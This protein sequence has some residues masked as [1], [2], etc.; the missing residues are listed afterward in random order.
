MRLWIKAVLLTLWHGIKILAVGTVAAIVVRIPFMVLSDE[1]RLLLAA[2]I[3]AAFALALA[4][5]LIWLFADAVRDNYGRL[6]Y[7]EW[8]EKSARGGEKRCG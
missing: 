8:L 7:K 5:C 6:L 4:A 3:V 1:G 2:I